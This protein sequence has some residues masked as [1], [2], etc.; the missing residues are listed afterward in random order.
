MSI[1][2]E[3]EHYWFKKPVPRVHIIGKKNIQCQYWQ[4]MALCR[5]TYFCRASLEYILKSGKQPNVLHIH[6]WQTAAVAPIFWEIYAN[7][8]T[9]KSVSS[10][11]CV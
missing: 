9:R 4:L 5:F 1:F 6:N 7:Q 8:V 3:L 11:R 2:W 10:C